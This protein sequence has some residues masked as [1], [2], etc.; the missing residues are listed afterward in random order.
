MDTVTE[1]CAFSGH[2]EIPDSLLPRLNTLLEQK[3]EALAEAGC[4]RFYCGGARGFDMLAADAVLR[5]RSRRPEIRLILVLPCPEQSDRWP[6][7]LRA[8]YARQ[9]QQADEVVT[10]SPH[11]TRFCMMQRNRYMVDRS[12]LLIAYLTGTEGGT[13]ATVAYALKK[14]IPVCNLAVELG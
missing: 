10:L 2:R 7:S 6:E 1:G 8:A 11:Y 14:G 12:G 3:A 5:V 13:A 9:K 4:R